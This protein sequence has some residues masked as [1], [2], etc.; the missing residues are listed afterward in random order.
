MNKK[1]TRETIKFAKGQF[2]S[3][4]VKMQKKMKSSKEAFVE[5]FLY[6]TTNTKKEYVAAIK[7]FH[8]RINNLEIRT[9]VLEK[10]KGKNE[11]KQNDSGRKR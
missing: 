8:V 3:L 5:G 1:E 2:D 10:L 7:V 9:R 6:G 11:V 4:T